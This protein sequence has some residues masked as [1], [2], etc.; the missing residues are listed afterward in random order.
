MKTLFLTLTEFFYQM[1]VPLAMDEIPSL[2]EPEGT[3]LRNQLKLVSSLFFFFFRCFLFLFLSM[4]IFTLLY[5]IIMLRLFFLQCLSQMSFSP[6][7][8]NLYDKAPLLSQPPIE[9]DSSSVIYG[10]DMDSVDIAVR[11]ALVKFFCSPNVLA[12]FTKHT[13][14]LRLYPRP[15]VAFL[16]EAFV[17]SRSEESSYIKALVETQ[18]NLSYFLLAIFLFL[19]PFVSL[20]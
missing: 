6:P 7:P 20:L 18:V 15:V 5:K 8:V 3:T 1:S 14:V 12:N 11:S 16:K 10:S 2:P 4:I 13:R 17:K 19:N 9:N